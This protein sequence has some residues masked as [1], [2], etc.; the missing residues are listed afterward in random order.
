MERS[1]SRSTLAVPDP[2]ASGVSFSRRVSRLFVD[3][4][5]AS[6]FCFCFNLSKLKKTGEIW[7]GYSDGFSY[8]DKRLK[9]RTWSGRMWGGERGDAVCQKDGAGMGADIRAGLHNTNDIILKC[10]STYLAHCIVL[11]QQR[12]FNER[13]HQLGTIAMVSI[14]K[15]IREN[16]KSIN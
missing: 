10:V 7:R 2:L 13:S 16:R 8:D 6:P 5:S 15:W 11:Q 9:A 4:F 12:S 14:K 1:S 3:F